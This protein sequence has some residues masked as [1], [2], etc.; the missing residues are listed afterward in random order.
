M[1]YTIFIQIKKPS[2]SYTRKISKKLKHPSYL[3]NP[4]NSSILS[5][6]P[7]PYSNDVVADLC[8]GGGTTAVCSVLLG[9]R[10]IGAD[11]EENTVKTTI[12]R[13]HS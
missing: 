3:L 12:G 8:V 6:Q 2:T 9:R 4:K 11:I 13:V 1:Y 7:Y 10:F 5:T